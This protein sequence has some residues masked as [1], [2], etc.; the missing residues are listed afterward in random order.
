M[1]KIAFYLKH[2]DIRERIA[3]N[4]REKTLEFHTM[5]ERLTTIFETVGN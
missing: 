1:D 4:G 2:D 5:Q 3:Q